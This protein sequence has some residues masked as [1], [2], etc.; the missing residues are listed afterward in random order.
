MVKLC[1]SMLYATL[2]TPCFA[3]M[4]TSH[5]CTFVIDHA[6]QGRVQPPE[7]ALV[8]TADYDQ[9]QGKPRCI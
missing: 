6:E 1:M 3:F 2:C 4:L 9:D 5:T 8:K 7:P